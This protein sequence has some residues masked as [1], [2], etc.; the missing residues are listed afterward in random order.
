MRANQ[1]ELIQRGEVPTDFQTD[2]GRRVGGAGD[3][4]AR[5]Q[6]VSSFRVFY[7]AGFEEAISV[8]HCFMKKTQA[9]R[10]SNMDLGRRRYTALL[11]LRRLR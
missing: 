10:K 1:L 11:E 8:L 3:P 9:T 5:S 2:A 7:L 6:R 4:A